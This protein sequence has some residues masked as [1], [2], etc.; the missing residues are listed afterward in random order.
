MVRY[1]F[2]TI[3]DRT[4]QSPLVFAHQFLRY[5]IPFYNFTVSLYRFLLQILTISELL[6]QPSY[7]RISNTA[8]LHHVIIWCPHVVCGTSYCTL[9]DWFWGIAPPPIA[10]CMYE[11]VI[12]CPDGVV[13]LLFLTE[14][15]CFFEGRISVFR[16]GLLLI[17]LW[18]H[19]ALQRGTSVWYQDQRLRFDVFLT[20]HHSID[21]FQVTNLM[22]ISFIL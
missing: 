12:C 1:L 5:P 22:H 4:Y 2:Y 20:V 21:I 3:G 19:V 8:W 6:S 18:H 11:M 13:P 15:W 14:I 9:H 7:Q 17:W 10:E 16:S